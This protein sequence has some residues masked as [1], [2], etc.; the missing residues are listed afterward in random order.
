[1]T[2]N[3]P[4]GPPRRSR[5]PAARRTDGYPH[6]PWLTALWV[7]AAVLAMPLGG[8]VAAFGGSL[9]VPGLLLAIGAGLALMATVAV[10][11]ATPALRW[12]GLLMLFAPLIAVPIMAMHATQDTVLAA[13]GTAHRATVTEVKV[14]HGKSTTYRCVVRY[15]DQPD[16]THTVDDCSSADTPGEQLRIIDD[17]AGWVAPRFDYEVGSSAFNRTLTLFFTG[18][19]LVVAA[20]FALSGILLHSLAARGAES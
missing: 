7:P 13:R 1:V 10:L 6:R 8:A 18:C 20:F 11:C 2:D 17:P 4:A 5:R 9:M 3:A 12:V 19:T 16:R 15:D 14:S